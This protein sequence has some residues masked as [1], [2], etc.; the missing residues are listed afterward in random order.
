VRVLLV[1]FIVTLLSFAVTLLFTI[2]VMMLR[3][4][5]RGV[6]PHMPFAYRFVAAPVAAGVGMV[7]LIAM[8]VLEIRHYKR[9]RS[10]AVQST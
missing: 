2:A 9:L 1:T 8:M 3:G 6:M 5:L 7:V 10:G 4:W